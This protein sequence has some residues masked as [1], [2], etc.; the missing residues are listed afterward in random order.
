MNLRES[1]KKA[2][3]EQCFGYG[4]NQIGNYG[5]MDSTA[6]NYDPFATHPC[7]SIGPSIACA[8]CNGNT[9]WCGPGTAPGECCD[10]P[11][12]TPGCTDPTANNYDPTATI[13][14]G[15]CTYSRTFHLFTECSENLGGTGTLGLTYNGL[16]GYVSN[17]TS[18]DD[19]NNSQLFYTFIG[20]PNIGQVVNISL[21]TTTG[22]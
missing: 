9:D 17:G 11:I 22:P 7:N 5:C 10:Y 4:N 20:S 8:D 6:N 14:D 1:I 15:S 13:D 3:R 21:T 12:T 2:L 19:E 18:S 16:P